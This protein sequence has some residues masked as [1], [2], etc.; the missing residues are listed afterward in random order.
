MAVSRPMRIVCVGGGPAGLAFA[1]LAKLDNPELDVAVYER[2]PAGVT[3]GWGVVF[4]EPLLGEMFRTDPVTA[5][6]VASAA[7]RWSDQQVRVQGRSPIHLGGCGYAIG[8]HRLLEILGTRAVELGVRVEYR[9]EVTDVAEL[10]AADL[11]V[12]CDGVHSQLRKA[13]EKTFGTEIEVGSNR[14]LWLG[15]T[16]PFDAFTFGFEKAAGGWIWFHAYRFD[17]CTST[18][19]VEC[20]PA[21]WERMGF[22]E[23]DADATVA[24]LEKIFARY[25]QGHSLINQARGHDKASWLSFTRI[26]NRR[27]SHGNVVLMG[28]AAHTAH[29]SIGS[30]TTL[31]M[32]D[33]ITL[34][35]TLTCHRD[36]PTA[37]AQYHALRRPEVLALQTEADSSSRWFE[38]IEER[39]H[40]DP[41]DFGFSMLRRRFT[42]LPAGERSPLWRYQM[43]VATQNAALRRVRRRVTHLRH[44]LRVRRARLGGGRVGLLA[45]P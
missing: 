34:A 14:Y 25:L 11:V 41:L 16:A 19:I 18:F 13:D 3:Y 29:F 33:A 26:T 12:A 1:S 42:H 30:G 7:A 17:P 39:I 5:R 10:G 6:Q 27:W 20:S 43:H 22:P 36:V 28:D 9:Q 2:N 44:Q 24:R 35:T 32:D 8:R 40:A 23:L 4:G 38:T 45:P 15:T 21:T 37:L 31:A